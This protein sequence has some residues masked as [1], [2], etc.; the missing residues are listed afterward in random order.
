MRAPACMKNA[1]PKT[2]AKYIVEDNY[3]NLKDF[4]FIILGKPGP[5]GKTWLCNKLKKHGLNAIELTETLLD[6]IDYTGH[7]SSMNDYYEDHDNKYVVIILNRP[8][9]SKMNGL[10]HTYF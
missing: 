10:E 9:L 4:T 2:I 8:I 6:Y 3:E 1:F 5:T 7:Q